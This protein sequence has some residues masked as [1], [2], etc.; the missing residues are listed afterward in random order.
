MRKLLREKLKQ[1][2]ERFHKYFQYLD[3][4]KLITKAP[5]LINSCDHLILIPCTTVV[6]K[7]LKDVIKKEKCFLNINFHNVVLYTYSTPDTMNDFAD[8]Q[9]TNPSPAIVQGDPNCVY[10]NS[11]NKNKFNFCVKNLG[12][13]LQLI[14]AI[15]FYHKC[16]GNKKTEEEEGAE[17]LHRLLKRRGG[18]LRLS[19]TQRLLLKQLKKRQGSLFKPKGRKLFQKK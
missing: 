16:S 3:P 15:K 1:I 9:L 4:E 19:K 17:C 2:P 14:E 7:T 10:L 12:E 18:N 11:P 13:S 6:D 8:L 5:Y